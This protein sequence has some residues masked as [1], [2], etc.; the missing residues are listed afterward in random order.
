[1][2]VLFDLARD[3][4]NA[5]RYER[6]ELGRTGIAFSGD[7]ILVGSSSSYA[8]LTGTGLEPWQIHDQSAGACAECGLDVFRRSGGQWQPPN[9]TANALDTT[10]NWLGVGGWTS[11]GG[12]CFVNR[13]DP[14]T[15]SWRTVVHAADAGSPGGWGV[16]ATIPELATC[17][18]LR[19]AVAVH[20]QLMARVSE[21][22][23][24]ACGVSPGTMQVQ[25]QILVQ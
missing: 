6:I 21:R 13:F 25:V 1:D 24:P 22:H 16:V 18:D 7:D 4:G 10:A 2:T 23:D 3:T 8:G 12:R 14:L 9:A 19:G 20:G 5:C 17:D 11:K 15:T